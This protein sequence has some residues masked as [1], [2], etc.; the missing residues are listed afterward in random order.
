MGYYVDNLIGIK[1]G[2]VFSGE[3]DHNDLK[4]RIAKIIKEMRDTDYNPPIADDPSHCLSREL[5]GGKG[6]YVTIAG[7]FNYWGFE[8]ASEFCKK[9]S[10]EFGTEIML[11]S[12]DEQTNRV[13]CQIFLDGKPLFEV[14]ENPIGAVI[15]RVG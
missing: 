12:W 11:M 8:S 4:N 7:V 6:S 14:N 3:I 10:S 15:R 5:T 9:L 1:C 2:G 13:Q